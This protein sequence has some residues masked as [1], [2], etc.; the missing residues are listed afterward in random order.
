MRGVVGLGLLRWTSS[1]LKVGICWCKG[2]ELDC[3][4]AVTL[5]KFAPQVRL[6]IKI[7]VLDF[8]WSRSL[9]KKL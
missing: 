2:S 8:D 5:L 9:K 4:F 1:N 7:V 3:S 6:R